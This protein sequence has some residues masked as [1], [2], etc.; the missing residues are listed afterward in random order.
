MKGHGR[1]PTGRWLHVIAH[2]KGKR[3]GFP[4]SFCGIVLTVE[5]EVAAWVGKYLCQRCVD[6]LDPRKELKLVR[7]S[8]Q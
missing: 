5:A 8:Y 2:H 4:I 6:G 3:D 1:T 7:R